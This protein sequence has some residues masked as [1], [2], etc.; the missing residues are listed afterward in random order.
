MLLRP[1]V[2][3]SEQRSSGLHW[4]ITENIDHWQTSNL[5]YFWWGVQDYSTANQC[6]DDENDQTHEAQNDCYL[7]PTRKSARFHCLYF[8]GLRFLFFPTLSFRVI[9]IFFYGYPCMRRVRE[10]IFT[11]RS[12]HQCEEPDNTR[13]PR[14]KQT[15]DEHETGQYYLVFG[16]IG[17]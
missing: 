14:R 3:K 8:L 9:G 12:S 13:Q 11:F 10:C 2:K 1:H 7:T 15:T 17:I 6:S 5:M 4:Q 16:L